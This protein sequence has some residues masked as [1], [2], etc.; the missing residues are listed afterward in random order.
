MMCVQI[1]PYGRFQSVM[2][3]KDTPVSYDYERGE[4]VACKKGH[5]S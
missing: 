4:P 1:R 2:F 3:D 5:Q